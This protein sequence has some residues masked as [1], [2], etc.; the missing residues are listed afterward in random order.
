MDI[1]ANEPAYI[2]KEHFQKGH[3]IRC[4]FCIILY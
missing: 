4:P 2:W 3:P 1:G